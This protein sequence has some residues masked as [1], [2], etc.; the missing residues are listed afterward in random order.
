MLYQCPACIFFG[1]CISVENQDT[2]SAPS[3]QLMILAS[4]AAM[5]SKLSAC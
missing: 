4:F 3:A 5:D 1:V 2:L